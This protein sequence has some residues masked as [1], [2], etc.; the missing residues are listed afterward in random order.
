MANEAKSLYGP[1][2]AADDV[3][4]NEEVIRLRRARAERD[5]FGF[6][7]RPVVVVIDYQVAFTEP[8]GARVEP[9]LA[10]TRRLIEVARDRAI[11]VIYTAQ[12]WDSL[13]SASP[14]WQATQDLNGFVGDSPL[15]A[16]DDRIAPLAGERLIVKPHASAFFGTDVHEHLSELGVDTVLLAGTSTSG[17]V[18]ATAV[19]A[20]AL[21]YRAVLVEECTYDPRTFS[22]E[23]AL[24]DLADRYA[25]VVALAEA[26]AYLSELQ[27]RPSRT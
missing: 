25:D 10:A 24:W 19:D 13:E 2:E 12:G 8:S 5:R 9:A 6:G 22:R 1:G 18:R 27:S 20:A 17:C 14:R 16:V 11:P 23:A 26:L 7:E 3:D 21:G 4:F 15:V